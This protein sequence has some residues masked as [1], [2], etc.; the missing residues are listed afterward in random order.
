MGGTCNSLLRN[1]ENASFADVHCVLSLPRKKRAMRSNSP[2]C[3]QRRQAS[4]ITMCGTMVCSAASRSSCA[5]MKRTCALCSRSWPFS[6]AS[7]PS[8]FFRLWLRRRSFAMLEWGGSAA[9]SQPTLAVSRSRQTA[10]E[11]IRATWLW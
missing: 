1:T 3:S 6:S 7:C 5:Y 10:E 8:C 2:A 4:R 9:T 11:G